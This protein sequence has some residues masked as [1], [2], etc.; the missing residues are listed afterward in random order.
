MFTIL[1]KDTNEMIVTTPQ[2]RI[3]QRSKLVDT[4][5]F[6]VPSTYKEMDMSEFIVL[7]EYKLPVSNECHS[8]TLTLSDE[9][10]KEYL[11][12]KVPFDTSLTKEAGRIEIQLTFLKNEMDSEGKV[13]QYSRKISPCYINIIPINAWSNMVPDAE[14]AAIDQRILKLDAIANQITDVQNLVIDRKADDISY[15]NNTIQLMANGNKIGT[16]HVLDQQNE[17]DV[18]E[19]GNTS[20]SDDSD[21]DYTLVEF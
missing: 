4:L 8:E 21:G 12:Y 7:L 6:L 11:E 18:V 5:H 9:L 2:E 1:V 10:Y 16:S 17:F 15:E 20:D 13:T 3:M 14:L 19:F